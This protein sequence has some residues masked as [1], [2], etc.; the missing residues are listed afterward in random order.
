VEV[1]EE[2]DADDMTSEDDWAR[3]GQRESRG[4]LTF[5]TAARQAGPTTLNIVEQPMDHR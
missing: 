4:S 1:P 3:H 2:S 5:Y